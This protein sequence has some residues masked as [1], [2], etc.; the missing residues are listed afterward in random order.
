MRHSTPDTDAHAADHRGSGGLAAD[1]VAGQRAQLEEVT[2]G[3]DEQLDALARQELTGGAVASVVLGPAAHPCLRQRGRHGGQRVEVGLVVGPE[4][5]VA[6]V[7]AGGKDGVASLHR[8]RVIT[9]R[10]H[11]HVVRRRTSEVTRG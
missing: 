10:G 3:I 8:V 4:D 1:V 6:R 5:R 7:D 9:R 11:P 2:V